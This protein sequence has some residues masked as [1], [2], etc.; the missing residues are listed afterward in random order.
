MSSFKDEDQPR[1]L[2]KS[3]SETALNE[4]DTKADLTYIAQPA[5]D[6]AKQKRKKPEFPTNL[7]PPIEPNDSGMLDVGDG[8]SM[9]WEECGQ[10]ASSISGAIPAV[11]FLHGGPG[12][13]CSP[14]S[15]RFFDPSVFRIVCVDQRGCG[16]SVPNAADDWEKSL[17]ENNTAKLV[18]D[19]ETIR[20]KLNIP[21]W[22]MVLGGSW[23]STLAL[24]Y[25]EANPKSMKHIVLRGVFLFSP[26]E[27]GASERSERAMRTKTSNTP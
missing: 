5:T 22:Y 26:D 2:A 10:K 27:V 7:Y 6:K 14:N 15:R 9:Y 18:S 21:Q 23:G 20:K 8:H 24:A 16:R 1:G 3:L 17:Y 25:A 4:L 13:G 19:M 11:I 12:G